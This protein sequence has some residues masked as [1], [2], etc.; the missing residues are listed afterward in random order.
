MCEEVMRETE[1]IAGSS[2]TGIAEAMRDGAAAGARAAQDLWDLLGSGVAK[3]VYGSAYSLAYGATFCAM[4]LGHLIP[5]ES[6]MI[7]G[8]HDGADAALTAF[9]AWEHPRLAAP[10][11]APEEA[12]TA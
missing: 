9:D 1:P 7:K 8:L 6:L 12:V 5:R 10:E 3:G 4:L 11:G 2:V